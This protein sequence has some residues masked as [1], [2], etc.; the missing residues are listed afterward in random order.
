MSQRTRL[1][2]SPLPVDTPPPNV[3][4][5]LVKGAPRF[6]FWE[7]FAGSAGLSK[8]MGRM[9]I[10]NR[11]AVVGPPIS[12]EYG[13]EISN[14]THQ[15]VLADLQRLRQPRILMTSPNCGPWSSSNTN[16]TPEVLEEVRRWESSALEFSRESCLKQADRGDDFILGQPRASE[17]LCQPVMMFDG[18][19]GYVPDQCTAS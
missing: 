1:K 15:A 16:M 8:Q 6:D 19:P 5:F 4:D 9:K 11:S 7:W 18:V 12:R 13:W 3:S 10:G 14:R 2:Y 17:L